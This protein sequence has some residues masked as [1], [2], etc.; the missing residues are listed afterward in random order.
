LLLC[1]VAAA[2]GVDDDD[3]RQGA[4]LRQGP[5][6]RPRR[7]GMTAPPPYPR[8]AHLV[9]GRGSSDDINLNAGEV[10]ALLAS[11]VVVEEKLDGANVVLWL[12]DE[13]RIQCALRSGPGSMDR[14]GQL[15]PLRA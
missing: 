13:G 2:G 1:L 7:T 4:E 6:G 14:A 12:E 8:V 15:G 5:L 9:P 11:E 3:R 10:A